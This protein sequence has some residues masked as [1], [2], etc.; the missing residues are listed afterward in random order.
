MQQASELTTWEAEEIL[1][2]NLSVSKPRF[3]WYTPFVWLFNT[4]VFIWYFI[5]SMSLFFLGLVFII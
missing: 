3:K 1:M 5:F 2:E 4:L